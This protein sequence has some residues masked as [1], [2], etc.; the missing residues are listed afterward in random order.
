[1]R[2]TMHGNSKKKMHKPK[3]DIER[4]VINCANFQDIK[5]AQMLAL[6]IRPTSLKLK[7]RTSV[8]CAN[9]LVEGI[10]SLAIS[11]EHLGRVLPFLAT[12]KMEG[13]GRAGES[14]VPLLRQA[15]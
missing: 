5:T 14:T 12:A 7:A 2:S 3:Q 11:E 15:C 8:I 13:L 10:S 9:L 6:G 4:R 1:M